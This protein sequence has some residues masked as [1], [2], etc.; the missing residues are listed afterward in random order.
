[1]YS[2]KI[3]AAFRLLL[4][5]SLLGW[6]QFV[7]AVDY[8]WYPSYWPNNNYGTP[9]A[10]CRAY[11]V[12]DDPRSTFVSVTV[13]GSSAL[14]Y[15]KNPQYGS[16]RDLTIY[17]RG[18]SCPNGGTYNSSTGA[19]TA[20]KNCPTTGLTV[21]QEC[22]WIEASKT[23]A[24]PDSVSVNSCG[25]LPSGN[26]Q[27][28]C[29][30]SAAASPG[31]KLCVMNY[32]GT[33][34]ASD[35]NPL[36]DGTFKEQENND[37]NKTC[38]KMADGTNFCYTNSDKGCGTFNG[39]EG[40][41][42]TDQ[43]CG[44]VNGTFTCVNSGSNTRNCG[45]ANG[46]QVCFNPKDPTKIIDPSSSDH[47]NNG[48]NGDGDD[49]NDPKPSGSGSGSTGATQGSD[50]AATNKAVQDVG[51][52]ISKEQGETNDLLGDIKGLLEDLV[53][54]DSGEY[55]GEGDGAGNGTAPGE[56]AGKG[57]AE[58]IT[59]EGDALLKSRQEQQD[60]AIAGIDYAVDVL[61]P[62][63]DSVFRSTMLDQLLPKSTGCADYAI[64]SALGKY[65]YSINIPVCDLSRAKALLEY[66]L[67]VVTMI[68]LFVTI[69]R[70]AFLESDSGRTS[71]R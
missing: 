11:M 59:K 35:A 21:A 20:P 7:W 46:Q 52:K 36:P 55:Q 3:R 10:A 17:R 63:A 67:W 9:E 49:T 65:T 44:Y 47:P 1:M 40:C 66:V 15:Y 71:R 43:N 51:D 22:T 53:G 56:E 64:Q 34:K 4:A 25:Y 70:I 32:T 41:F 60:S 58:S 24:C 57:L 45:Y 16:N 12:A 37:P 23:A 30:T 8:S 69:K 6:G 62:D 54:K 2:G 61:L 14:C 27:T 39:K 31:K 13:S 26:S 50:S 28:R 68:G 19:C 29:Y 18:D 5:L 48:G 33:G 38:V 42:Q